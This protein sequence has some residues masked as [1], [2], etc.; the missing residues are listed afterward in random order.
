MSAMPIGPGERE[1]IL[2]EAEAVISGS[3][4]RTVARGNG[5][6]PGAVYHDL[7]VRLPLISRE[8]ADQ[9]A[10]AMTE[11]REGAARRGARALRM[12]RL[13]RDRADEEEWREEDVP[14]PPARRR[15]PRRSTPSTPDLSA[16]QRGA[17]AAAARIRARSSHP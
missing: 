11:H 10:E 15:P 4:I 7:R 2:A 16:L 5:H 6:T 17:L 13:G 9:V 8:V 3:S 14:P 1:R 12:A